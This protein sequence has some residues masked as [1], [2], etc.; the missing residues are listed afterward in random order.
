ME[1]FICYWLN[2][3]LRSEDWEEI[4]V[5]TPYLVCLVYTFKRSEYISKY[6]E[7]R[8]GWL[9]NVFGYAPKQKLCLY[10]GAALRKEHFELYVKENVKYFSWNGVTSTSRDQNIAINFIRLSLEKA[11]N[12][13]EPK[14]GVIFKIEAEL[15]SSEDCQG[16][17]DI[18]ENS[19]SEYPDEQ[20]VILAPGTVF[21]LIKTRLIGKDI[22]EISLKVTKEFEKEKVELLGYLQYQAILKDK[23]IIDGF[24]SQ[25]SFRLL[26]L[27]KGNKLIKKL[28]IKNSGIEEHIMEEIESLRKTTHVKKEDFKLFSNTIVVSSLGFLAHYFSAEK[29]NEIFIYNKIRFKEGKSLKKYEEIESLTLSEEALERIYQNNQLKEL[30]EKIKNESQMKEL[31]LSIKS[32]EFISCLE[33]L[34]DLKSLQSLRLRINKKRGISKEGF[35]LLCH[36]IGS[37]L[38]GLYLECGGREFRRRRFL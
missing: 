21:K 27:L 18:Y 38:L 34:K 33:G 5:L 19:C 20:E 10:R 12:L 24:P 15:S 9:Y 14:V 7:S 16:M 28:E 29:L 6:Q 11:R 30:G 23:A 13:T 8:K 26:E 35:E 22:H 2:E 1:T 25:Q 17:I 32:T 4:N 37:S 31:D 3:L 36:A